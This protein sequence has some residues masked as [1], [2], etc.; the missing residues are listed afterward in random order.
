MGAYNTLS[1]IFAVVS[2]RPVN[3]AI[4]VTEGD[5]VTGQIELLG[6]I[7][8]NIQFTAQFAVQTVNFG[9]P[10]TAGMSIASA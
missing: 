9:M 7:E 8:R 6:L 3:S 1:L 10:A 2:I 5:S 4:G